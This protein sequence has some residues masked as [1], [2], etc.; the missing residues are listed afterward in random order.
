[1]KV[2]FLLISLK[3]LINDVC[4]LWHPAGTPSEGT[5][6]PPWG[7]GTSNHFCFFLDVQVFD[8]HRK[9]APPFFQQLLSLYSAQLDVNSTLLV[10]RS[11]TFTVL[12]E[13]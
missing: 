2:S 12:A 6:E 1:M 7:S 3:R 10:R 13:T 4:R 11:F 8:D 5:G 9:G